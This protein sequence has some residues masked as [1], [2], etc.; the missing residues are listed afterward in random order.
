MNILKYQPE[1]KDAQIFIN[2]DNIKT[3]SY[4][5]STKILCICY[6]G[7]SVVDRLYVDDDLK[8]QLK[9]MGFEL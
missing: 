4:R 7:E 1:D 3:A 2:L 5:K 9:K 6:R 8:E